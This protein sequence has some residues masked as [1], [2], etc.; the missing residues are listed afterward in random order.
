VAETPLG[1]VGLPG[2]IGPVAAFLASADSGWI[3]GETLVVSGG[4]R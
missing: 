1:R 2:D 3:T 4:L